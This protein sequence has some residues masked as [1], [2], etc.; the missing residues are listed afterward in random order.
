MT[1]AIIVV[2]LLCLSYH[3]DILGKKDRNRYFCY[4]FVL[5]LLIL[6]S[7]LRYRIGVDTTRY[8]T[9]FFHEYPDLWDIT[10]DDFSYGSD[11]LYMLLNSL[12]HSLGGKFYVVQ[13]LHASFVN[14]L[15]FK[16]IK[17]HTNFIFTSVLFYFVLYYPGYNFD[18]M[19]ASMSIAICLYANDCIIEKKYIRGVFIYLIGCLFH[20]S[21]LF[22]IITIFLLK[23]R[24]NIIGYCTL[25]M[26]FFVG[27]YIMT[28]LEDYLK[29]LELGDIFS[30]KSYYYLHE[31]G[32]TEN[33]YNIY[34]YIGG[35]IPCVY[36]II[37]ILYLKKYKRID[38]INL[39][40]MVLIGI[41][42]SIIGFYVPIIKRLAVFYYIYF[43]L[44]D[45]SLF[46]SM[47]NRFKHLGIGLRLVRAIIIISPVFFITF[48]RNVDMKMVQCFYP[49]SSVFDKTIDPERERVYKYYEGDPAKPGEY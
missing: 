11:P 42:L 31:G 8:I 9:K 4:Y 17:K 3:Y 24:L 47:V 1:Y 10:W 26:A 21:T 2:I 16:Y 33:N 28:N 12:I 34:G 18:I 44:F 43:V 22:I 38:M 36:P 6:V 49:Y 48:K 19:R 45:A 13:L 25:I 7:G 41:I 5:F 30:T 27:S 39:E 40:P 37:S 14:F 23:L 20:F 35:L 15:I 32:S 29:M 46:I